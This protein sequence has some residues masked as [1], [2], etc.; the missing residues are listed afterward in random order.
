MTA[1]SIPLSIAIGVCTLMAAPSGLISRTA[2]EG[3]RL[4]LVQTAAAEEA[5][6]T[7]M[8][9]ICSKTEDSMTLTKDELKSLIERCDKLKP[10][11]EALEES[12]RKL[13]RKRLQMCREL[14]AFVLTSKE[15]TK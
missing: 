4:N 13:Y 7:E 14:F 8:E 3:F 6:R 2:A 12:P 9:E 5:W 11:I 15:Q 1:R 10:A